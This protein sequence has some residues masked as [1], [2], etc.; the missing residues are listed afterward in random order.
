MISYPEALALLLAEVRLLDVEQVGIDAARRRFLAADIASPLALPSFDN[1]AMD[2]YALR[3]ESDTIPAGTV[4]TVAAMH[5]AGDTADAYPGAEAC[6]IA[7]GARMPEGFDTVVPVE[8]CERQGAQ[9]RF[10]TDERRG[11]NVRHAGADIGEGAL[12][13]ERGRRIDAGAVMLLAALGIERVDVVRRPRVAVIA[14]GSELN[15]TGPLPPGGIHD[16][17][18]PFLAASLASWGVEPVRRARVPDVGDA[19]H[20]AVRDARAAGADL[21]VTTGAV[22]AGRFDFVPASLASLGAR[23]LFHKV[24]IRPGKPLLAARFDDGPLVLALP[25]NPI[26]VAV[27]YR[28]FVAPVLRAMAGLAA[29]RPTRVTMAEPF[30][31]R[32]GMRQF[33]LGR[34]EN[35][36]QGRQVAYLADA[37]AAYRILPYTQANTWLTAGSADGADAWP[38]DPADAA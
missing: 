3:A 23:E 10:L 21:I 30:A 5:A 1:A 22:S 14:T 8:R 28:F 13:L 19:F 33:A 11:Q 12:A 4:R 38:I 34:I 35:D 2:G 9:V 32:E 6:E 24:A 7:T 37:Q 36:A 17:N 18:G 20:A 15:A 29:E 26:A 31:G 25:G 16:S 27:G